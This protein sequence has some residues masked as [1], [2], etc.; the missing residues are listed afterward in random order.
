MSPLTPRE[1]ECLHWAAMGKTSW[2]IGTIIGLAES[3][4]NS[5]ISRVCEK[6]GVHRRQTAITTALQRGLI[7]MKTQ[8]V[9]SVLAK[10]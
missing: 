4:V 9:E 8:H 1:L 10:A 7:P 6:F 5:H 3:T 2:E